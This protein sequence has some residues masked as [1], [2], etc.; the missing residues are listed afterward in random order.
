MRQGRTGEHAGPSQPVTGPRSAHGGERTGHH[1][2][3][4]KMKARGVIVAGKTLSGP[5]TCPPRGGAS[6]GERTRSRASRAGRR[7][8]D[9]RAARENR[10][11]GRARSR[12][13]TSGA[14]TGSAARVACQERF[15]WVDGRRDAQRGEGELE[16]WKQRLAGGQSAELVWVRH[17]KVLLEHSEEHGVALLGH[18]LRKGHPGALA[19]LMGIKIDGHIALVLHGQAAH[20]VYVRLVGIQR[21][22]PKGEDGAKLGAD[23]GLLAHLALHAFAKGLAGVDEAARHLPAVN[24][25]MPLLD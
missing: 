18:I 16:L 4:G 11:G 17:T 25:A 13:A 20:K 19:D 14:R 8:Q 1:V 21:S 7:A 22:L 6:V 23:A 2:S 24:A 5:S 3:A 9:A 10:R 15:E 12:R